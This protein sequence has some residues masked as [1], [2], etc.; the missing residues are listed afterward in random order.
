LWHEVANKAS[1]LPRCLMC[2]DRPK[3]PTRPLKRWHKV[4]KVSLWVSCGLLTHLTFASRSDGAGGLYN[5]PH[6]AAP[7]GQVGAVT[8]GEAT[9]HGAWYNPALMAGLPDKSGLFDLTLVVPNQR[10]TRAPQLNAQNQLTRY[11]SVTNDATPT[12]APQLGLAHSFG[13]ERW[14]FSVH[15]FAPNGVGSRYPERGPQRYQ[16]IDTEGSVVWM[17]SLSVAYR[18]GSR[19]WLGGSLVNTSMSLRQVLM[20]SAY[21]GFLGAPDDPAFDALVQTRGS[22]LVNL[23]AQLGARVLFGPVTLGASLWL[24]THVRFDELQLKQRLPSHPIFDGAYV[25]GTQAIMEVSL[26]MIARLGA[27]YSAQLWGAELDLV[28]EDH[29]ALQS[30]NTYPQGIFVRD[31]AGGLDFEVTE[32]SVPRRFTETWS[33][34]LG[35]D[36]RALEELTLRAGVGWE[37]AAN[38]DE[39]LTIAAFDSDKWLVSLGAS[40]E[41]GAVTLD[42]G[43]ALTL[44]SDRVTQQSVIK[45]V[46]PLNP[47]G[48]QQ[49]GAGLY[50][51]QLHMLSL[52]VRVSWGLD[53]L[54]T[55]KLEPTP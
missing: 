3:R 2:H 45:Q 29:S 25:D 31:V 48:A 43:Y 51:G 46:N 15:G 26:P 12:L 39:A 8:A 23:S 35:G 50:Q 6:G 41:L 16:L 30:I 44:L 11:P 28:Y 27:R 14:R 34:R 40:W 4:L 9:L 52:G 49:V 1:H 37:Q 5:P 55:P 47:S 18:A 32:T 19:Y 10:Y 24:P 42:L 21:P 38:P 36:W 7:T 13:L 54:P 53:P 20:A 33:V 22:S 17:T